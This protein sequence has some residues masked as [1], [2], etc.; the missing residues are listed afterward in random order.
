M[1][2]VAQGPLH[3]SLLPQVTRCSSHLG[4]VTDFSLFIR[5]M[6]F[7]VILKASFR[8]HLS[9]LLHPFPSSPFIH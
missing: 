6:T 2:V 5:R 4:G 8:T 3:R 7:G 1:K 9:G